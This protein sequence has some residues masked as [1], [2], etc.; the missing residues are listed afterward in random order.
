MPRVRHINERNESVYH[1]LRVFASASIAYYS[2]VNQDTNAVA[3]H[4]RSVPNSVSSPTNRPILPYESP[5]SRRQEQ[6]LGEKFTAANKAFAK[7]EAITTAA[8]KRE[9]LRNGMS[10]RIT[11]YEQLFSRWSLDETQQAEILEIVNDRERRLI[12]LRLATFRE[13]ISSAT[14]NRKRMDVIRELAGV[15]LLSVMGAGRYGEFE[16]IDAGLNA[17][18]TAGDR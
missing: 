8:N 7:A 9:M 6:E 3:S 18:E 1:L 5:D 4:D 10:K 14:A 11:Q 13:G 15:E 17:K 2:T 16:T 12:E